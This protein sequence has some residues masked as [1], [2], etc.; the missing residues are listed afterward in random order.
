MIKVSVS[1]V[2]PTYNRSFALS[3][4]LAGLAVQ[5]VAPDQVV[6]ADDG[7]GDDTE[8][9][10]SAWRKKVPFPLLHVWQSDD[11]FRLARSRNRA[12]AESDADYI[13]FLDGDC[14]V[15]PDFVERHLALAECGRFIAG[16]RILLNAE[17][18][19]QVEML[20]KPILEWGFW[21]WVNARV[22]GQV[23]RILP[24]IRFPDARWR[25]SRALKWQGARGC[26]LG[27][28][29]KDYLAVNGC[30]ES[31]EG[32]GH[33]DAELVSRLI[34]NGILRKEGRFAVPVLHLWHKESDRR[35]E[36]ENRLRLDDVIQ[37]RRPIYAAQGIDRYL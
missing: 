34:R 3:R 21:S 28:W 36:E 23:N 5:S 7:S 22:R 20:G 31:F 33:D 12:V 18:T 9:V 16:S 1:V 10:I 14:I 24:L 4:V 8:Q 27:I 37:G 19:H 26:N 2:V 25:L 6:V 13:I 29:R 35:F 30:D 15:F 17:L 32:W 11:G